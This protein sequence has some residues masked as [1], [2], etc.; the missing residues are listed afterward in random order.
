[1]GTASIFDAKPYDFEKARRRR[2]LL[3]TI[4][5]AV[6]VIG[7]LLFWFRNWP[8]EHKVDH[9]F[10][11]L[12]QKN[13]EN[14]YGVWMNDGEWK[15]HPQQYAR[16]DFNAFLADWG[17]QGEWGVITSHHVDFAVAPKHSSGLV[18]QTTVNERKE[19][20][21]LFVDKHDGTISFPPEKTLDCK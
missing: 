9:F 11:A 4:T 16:Y 21:C 1:M 5:V 13:Y 6:I 17:P 8:Y 14:A 7:G 18:I 19:R 2:N 12:E 3:I 20:S 10:S 15:Q